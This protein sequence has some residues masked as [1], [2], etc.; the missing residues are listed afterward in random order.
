MKRT[1]FWKNYLGMKLMEITSAIMNFP[2]RTLQIG[3]DDIPFKMLP[4]NQIIELSEATF[5]AQGSESEVIYMDKI[6]QWYG[7]AENLE[8]KLKQVLVDSQ[9]GTT[10]MA[11]WDDQISLEEIME[12]YSSEGLAFPTEDTKQY[13]DKQLFTCPAEEKSKFDDSW[14]E[15]NTHLSPAQ[16]KRVEELLRNHPDVPATA[17]APLGRFKLF[18]ISA[19][20]KTLR[21]A[22][23]HRRKVNFDLAQPDIESLG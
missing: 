19:D 7:N 17:E 16:V 10:D 6:F 22:T 8:E 14:K 20:V 12:D 3:E 5:P 1:E 23:Q 21:D 13:M 9:A 15:K 4:P 11:E 18:Q 2:K